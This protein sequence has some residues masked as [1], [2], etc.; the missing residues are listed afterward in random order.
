MA[1]DRNHSL[2]GPFV[3][4]LCGKGFA[5]PSKVKKH[6]WGKK[7]NDLAT[8]TG[9]WAK[10]RKPDVAWDDHPSCK[11]GRPASETMKPAPSL[12]RQ[13]RPK[14]AILDTK[15]Q[16]AL[17]VSQQNTIPGFPTLDDLPHT[18]AR[19][20]STGTA[21]IY[22]EGLE[23]GYHHI[24]RT[25]SRS[26]FDSLLTAVNVVA[27]IDAPQPQS[28]TD[29]IALHLDAQ[30]AAAERHA[31]HPFFVPFKA[32]TSSFDPRFVRPVVPT[33]LDATDHSMEVPSTHNMSTPRP[34]HG[35]DP[36]PSVRSSDVEEFRT[37]AA[38]SRPFEPTEVLSSGS[39]KKRKV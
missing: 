29:S 36:R 38:V 31:Q 39:R 19:A 28:R 8:T 5:T 26:S 14:A 23:P 3:H 16:A 15:T 34:K 12:S 22:P 25:P 24:H 6:H 11:D 1:T 9:C 17:D 37:P 30:V 4:A 33:V 20:L 21:T 18:V 2:G 7:H 27:Q 32:L 13:I 10:H 35:R